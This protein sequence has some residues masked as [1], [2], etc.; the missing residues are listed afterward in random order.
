MDLSL[1]L[2][3][4]DQDLEEF[5]DHPENTPLV[6]NKNTPLQKEEEKEERPQRKKQEIFTYP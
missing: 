1:Q 2:Q 3:V 4:Q 5:P 6:Q